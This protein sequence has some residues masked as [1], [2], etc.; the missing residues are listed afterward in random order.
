MDVA[1]QAPG[2][3]DVRKVA[4]QLVDVPELDANR[5]SVGLPTLK[6]RW[7]EELATVFPKVVAAYEK[8]IDAAFESEAEQTDRAKAL[9]KLVSETGG[10]KTRGKRKEEGTSDF[11]ESV[12]KRSK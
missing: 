8:D 11:V 5:T 2:G 7:T 12:G 3:G 1:S 10:M 9:S 4:A 6:R